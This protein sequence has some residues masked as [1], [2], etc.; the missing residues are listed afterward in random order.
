MIFKT[1]PYQHQLETYEL[2]KDKEYFAYLM[3][4]GL[5]KTKVTIDVFNNLYSKNEVNAILVLAPKSVYMNWY[6]EFEIH[7]NQEVYAIA[8]HSSSLGK[9][10]KNSL[11]YVINSQ[12][13]IP[14]VLLVNT[15]SIRSKKGFTACYDF[16]KLNRVMM[17]VDESTDIKT[18]NSKQTVAATNLGTMAK[19]R[20][21]L[22]GTPIS[23]DPLDLYSQFE[24]LK[25]GIMQS[26]NFYAFKYTYAN[27]V[28]IDL[29]P[30]RPSYEKVNGFM[31]LDQLKRIIKPHCVRILK[32][33]CLDLP[34]KIYSVRE[35]ELSAEQKAYYNQLKELAII[36]H[37]KGELTVQSALETMNKLHQITCG[38]L[39]LDNG[40][41]IRFKDNNK[42]KEINRITKELDN[43]SKVIIWCNY[44][45]DV[46]ILHEEI[47]Q[48]VTYYG[49]N[50]I[51]QRQNAIKDFQEGEAKYFIS[52]Q[53]CGGKGIT[54][55]AA[56]YAIY[57]SNGY[58]LLDRL[59]SEDRHHRIGQTKQCHYTDLVIKDTICERV[60]QSIQ[61]KGNDA[62]EFLSSMKSIKTITDKIEENPAELL[63]II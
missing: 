44:Q 51:E 45:E 34:N 3:E 13:P 5:G 42:L 38:H 59:Q 40:E 56:Q 35:L 50:T 62:E 14:K 29:G 28:K 32:K 61:K 26:T 36:M 31:N 46:R 12:I 49:P 17:V 43:E 39:K 48:S 33:D 25:Q 21:I 52:T 1:K 4:M 15:E 41:I 2:T 53:Q 57:Y 54:L 60:K 58:R 16:L 10:D 24:F 11:N 23:Q 22:T 18:H 6:K 20:R 47:K 9:K 30:G 37:E 27:I 8:H 55:T 19:V 63:K 7:F